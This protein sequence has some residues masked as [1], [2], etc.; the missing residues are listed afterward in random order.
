MNSK[1]A[2]V[3]VIL[4]LITGVSTGCSK[5][6]AS[7]ETATDESAAPV[8]PTAQAEN[9]AA[10]VQRSIDYLEGLVNRQEFDQA[11]QMLKQIE[12]KTLTPAQQQKVN[13]L[14]A[15]IPNG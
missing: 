12:T 1:T 15:K 2:F 9:D 8:D 10:L 5:K 14:K 7:S 6:E 13:A 4:A 11:R 3:V